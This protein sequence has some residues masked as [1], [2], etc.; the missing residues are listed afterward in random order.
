[1]YAFSKD[2]KHLLFTD[3][4]GTTRLSAPKKVKTDRKVMGSEV[5]GLA[6][7]S[8]DGTMAGSYDD[9]WNKSVL[10]TFPALKSAKRFDRFAEK[11]LVVHPEGTH[12]IV[13]EGSKL[14]LEPAQADAVLLPMRL[15]G[16]VDPRAKA[17]K[18]ASASLA[19]GQE[20]A[21]LELG[22][23]QQPQLEGALRFAHDGTLLHWDG[24]TLARGQLRG[25][26]VKMSWR[27]ALKVAAKGMRV[28]ASADAERCVIAVHQ[29]RR[30][31]VVE[32]LEASG[33]EQ[34]FELES[35]ATPALAGPYVAWQR[36]ADTVVRR[37]LRSGE[38]Q[39]FSVEV[40]DS[41]RP[42]D[43]T[44]SGPGTIFASAGGRL[45]FL[46]GHRESILD[47]I[48]G[49]EISRKLPAKELELRKALLRQARPYVEAARL[50]GVTVELGRAEF[51][52]KY[53]S[54]SI[55]H[56]ISGP[57][58]LVGALLASHSQSH[59]QNPSFPDNWRMG[60]YGS[61]GGLNLNDMPAP[62]AAELV[63]GYALLASAGVPFASTI[64][65]WSQAFEERSWGIPAPTDGE[66]LALLGQALLATVRDGAQAKL[67]FEALAKAGAPSLDEVMEGFA[68]YPTTGQG[69]PHDTAKFVGGVYNRLFGAEAAKLWVRLFCETEGFGGGSLYGDLDRGA[70]RPLLAAH[71]EAAAP[72]KA[73]FASNEVAEDDPRRWALDQLRQHLDRAG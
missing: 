41:K 48:K 24:S 63:E 69:L 19:G 64:Q 26:G 40:Y 29:G 27:R 57:G 1:M 23:K 59:W 21:A 5:G 13:P 8:A 47:L 3:C 43:E 55:T 25:T 12:Y 54:V 68:N 44:N 22:G 53:S 38:E 52:S 45:L 35:L 18:G 6:S 10:W 20:L 65:A 34:R 16:V 39:E 56:H 33:E 11:R 42:T 4:F 51:D 46:C 17:A 61:H 14:R 32:R 66:T 7:I 30:W 2:E 15:D 31:T 36:A 67:D 70:I 71:P 50:A 60:S 62:T 49:H 73:W 37:D 28:E 72:L 58:N 9:I